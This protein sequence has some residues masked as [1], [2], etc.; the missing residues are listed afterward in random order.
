MPLIVLSIRCWLIFI[1]QSTLGEWSHWYVHIVRPLL[2][3]LVYWAH[4]VSI[5]IFIYQLVHC[6]CCDQY[7]VSGLNFP[8]TFPG[9]K[10]RLGQSASKGQLKKNST[11]LQNRTRQDVSVLGTTL[12][13]LPDIKYIIIGAVLVVKPAQPAIGRCQDQVTRWILQLRVLTWP[14]LSG[15][16]SLKWVS[17]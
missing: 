12:W 9:I 8:K 2:I 11:S 10:F 14:G 13:W 3:T 4:E 17:E 16:P 15:R 5:H 6:G 1:D 7:H